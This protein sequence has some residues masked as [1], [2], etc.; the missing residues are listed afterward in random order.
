MSKIFFVL[1]KSCSGKDT[2][3]QSLKE[4]IKRIIDESYEKAKT[5]IAEHRDV[6]D[7]CAALL[8]E[9]EKITREEFEALFEA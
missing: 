9:K 5:I 1:G 7:R 3:F 8:L 6:L 4:N 2:I